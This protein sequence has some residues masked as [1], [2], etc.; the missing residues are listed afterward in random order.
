MR[1]APTVATVA[2]QTRMLLTP[3]SGIWR[4]SI[5]AKSDAPRRYFRVLAVCLDQGRL[6]C[7]RKPRLRRVCG[8]TMPGDIFRKQVGQS[9]G[10]TVDVMQGEHAFTRPS[11]H[12]R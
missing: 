11:A 5:G 4:E 7:A 9:R 3:C 10:F 12:R 2:L 6:R 8:V 1:L